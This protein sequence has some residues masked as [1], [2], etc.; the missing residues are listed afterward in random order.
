MLPATEFAAWADRLGLDEEV[1]RRIQEIRRA[2]PSRGVAGAVGNVTV[3]YPSRKMGWT[4]QGESIRGEWAAILDLEYDPDVLEYYDQA[5]PL[6]LQ[7]Q[8]RSG[9]LGR[10]VLH[11]PDFFVLRRGGAGYEECKPNDQLRALAAR[12][13][14]RYCVAADGT[15]RCPPAEQAADRF[16]FSYRIRCADDI[17]W[18]A[19]RNTVFLEDY[20]HREDLT[21]PEEVA[22]AIRVLVAAAPGL[23]L[24][25]LLH[26]ARERGLSVDAVYALIVR[27]RLYVDLHAGLL[28]EPEHVRVFLDEV[29]AVGFPMIGSTCV[30][31]EEPPRTITKA[32]GIL[33]EWDGRPRRIANVGRTVVT[34]ITAEG[35]AVEVPHQA[36]DALVAS[37]SISAAQAEPAATTR[38]AAG[39]ALVRASPADQQEAVRRYEIIQPYL[40]GLVPRS[41]SRT[42]RRWVRAW[43]LAAARHGDGFLGL[44]PRQKERGYRGAKLPQAT[45]ALMDRFISEHYETCTQRS[46]RATYAAFRRGCEA[47]GAQDPQLVPPSFETFRLRVKARSGPDQTRKRQG[48]R[49][50]YQQEPF[51][52]ELSLTTPRHG[53]RP[54]EIVHIDHT[55]LDVELVYEESGRG[56]GKC[57][58]SIAVDARTRRFLALFISYDPPSYRSCLAIFRILV[59]RWG[60]LPQLVVVD[61]GPEFSS[62]YFETFLARYE[63][64]KKTRPAAHPRHG[65]VCE[66]LLGTTTSQFIH[67]LRGNTQITKLARQVTSGVDPKRQACWTL[68]ALYDY[69]CRYADEIYDTLEHPALGQ[70]PRAAYTLGMDQGGERLA[71][72]VPYDEQF[73][74]LTLPS[75]AKGTATV[76][77]GRGVKIHAVYYWH[78]LFRDPLLAGQQV[79]VRYDPFD[80]GIAYVYVRARWIQCHSEH[81]TVL[82][83]HSERERALA[84]QRLRERARSHGQS[85]T[86]T[87]RTLA[88]FFAGVQTQE[89]ML[90]QRVRDAEGKRV[91]ALAR[92]G[93]SAHLEEAGEPDPVRLAPA[94]R[95][96]TAGADPGRERDD[97]PPPTGASTDEERRRLK[98]YGRFL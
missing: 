51:Y 79:P 29:Q 42:T 91:I 24:R 87:A 77:V 18:V 13:P 16:G 45:L 17:N 19:T 12:S 3:R 93:T 55:E 43:R 8:T 52:W 65:S 4:I 44:L 82:H 89:D 71:R 14:H 62:V 94:A 49:V 39:Q 88:T 98:A 86:S 41:L 78:D 92:V 7:Y 40:A 50:A 15:W 10:P 35:S 83:G 70:S 33:I 64:T 95:G 22:E 9:K 23:L 34:L 21:V 25:D 76:H 59:R 37:G 6:W 60:R 63:I 31:D 32:P 80:I 30:A 57:W 96:L 2:P 48:S 75:T 56:A 81:Y 84:T 72:L 20:L 66:R 74:M 36:F 54:W 73:R 5:G 85:F 11:T 69:L 53:D 1:R 28:A 38:S 58:L 67:N 61:R 90:E 46:M 27:H 97:Q 47:A 68:G 26:N